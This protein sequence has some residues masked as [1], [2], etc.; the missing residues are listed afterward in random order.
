[1]PMDTTPAPPIVRVVVRLPYNRPE[2]PLEDPPKVGFSHAF[3]I[4]G[5]MIPAIPDRMELGEGKTIVGGDCKV[6]RK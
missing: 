2:H 6:A 4:D 3:H 5:A 1:M